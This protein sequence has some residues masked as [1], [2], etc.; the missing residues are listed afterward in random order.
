VDG[1][2]N[3]AG[4]TLVVALLLSLGRLGPLVV[5]VPFAGLGVRL[6]LLG[7]GAGLLVPLVLPAA[8]ALLSRGL[9]PERLASILLHELGIGLLL[10]LGAA[11]PWAALR[12][13]GR[14]LEFWRTASLD[15]G[16]LERLSELLALGLFFGSGG[17]AL[18]AASLAKSYAAVPLP[19]LSAGL[20]T[21]AAGP[22]LLRV[23]RLFGL[24][25]LLALPMLASRLVAELFVSLLSGALFRGRWP[26]GRAVPAA[27]AAALFELLALLLGLAALLAVWK[28]HARAFV[29]N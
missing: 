22:L 29:I 21:A 7:C 1:L 12:S 23:S 4:S 27:G 8:A 24:A 15:A 9:A 18:L 25:L 14:L 11:L 3:A 13:A 5:A 17:G 20:L 26:Y 19:S 16:P 6:L 10:L 2:V 28:T